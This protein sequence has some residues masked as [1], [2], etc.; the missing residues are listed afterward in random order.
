MYPDVGMHTKPFEVPHSRYIRLP[1]VSY[2]FE[3]D[4][5]MI[6]KAISF[7][8]QTYGINI[9]MT[10]HQLSHQ[11]PPLLSCCVVKFDTCSDLQQSLWELVSDL[12]SLTSVEFISSCSGALELWSLR[13]PELFLLL[14]TLFFSWY[15]ISGADHRYS[16]LPMLSNHYLLVSAP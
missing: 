8:L 13:H 10:W 1:H 5:V 3:G 16:V 14:V 2:L 7:P 12:E 9:D 15:L 11:H 4:V 6:I